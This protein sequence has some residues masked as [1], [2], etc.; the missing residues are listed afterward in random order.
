MPVPSQFESSIRRAV[1]S[2][3]FGAALRLWHEFSQTIQQRASLGELT[4]PELAA[5][6]ELCAWTALTAQCARAHSQ[7]RLGELKASNR[8][9]QVYSQIATARG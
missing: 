1:S 7:R 6:R 5:A 4:L 3:E 9:A 8:A 2:G